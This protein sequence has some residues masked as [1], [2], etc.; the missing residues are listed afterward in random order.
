MVMRMTRKKPMK[1]KKVQIISDDGDA[2]LAT[3]NAEP[4]IEMHGHLALQKSI[5]SRTS[6]PQANLDCL[7]SSLSNLCQGH[8]K[9][10]DQTDATH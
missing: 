3:S 7:N 10:L 4:A 9:P 6:I 1:A 5:P 8:V 2:P